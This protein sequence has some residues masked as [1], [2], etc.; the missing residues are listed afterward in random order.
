MQVA[1]Q[2]ALGKECKLWDPADS[3]TLSPVRRRHIDFPGNIV[4]S[5]EGTVGGEQ[6]LVGPDSHHVRAGVEILKNV[7]N[8]HGGTVVHLVNIDHVRKSIR[9][10]GRWARCVCLRCGSLEMEDVMES[11]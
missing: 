2:G 7:R 11:E 1:D 9:Y 5:F 4:S 10:W 8:V 6:S 3:H